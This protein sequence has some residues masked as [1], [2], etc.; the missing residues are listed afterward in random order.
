MSENFCDSAVQKRQILIQRKYKNYRKPSRTIDFLSIILILWHYGNFLTF[1]DPYSD[2]LKNFITFCITETKESWIL[3]PEI[4]NKLS[5]KWPYILIVAQKWLFSSEWAI[6]KSEVWI[7]LMSC[8]VTELLRNLC[9][10]SL[11]KSYKFQNF[12][13]CKRNKVICAEWNAEMSGQMHLVMRQNA[14]F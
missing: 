7:N 11:K 5:I 1:Q 4:G 10:K 3:A 8:L 6:F 2:I 14:N 13:K 12:Q 9:F